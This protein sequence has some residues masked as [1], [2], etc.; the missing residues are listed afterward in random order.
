[1]HDRIIC[2]AGPEGAP[3]KAYGRPVAADVYDIVFRSIHVDVLWHHGREYADNPRELRNICIVPVY[4][5]HEDEAW[6][7]PVPI[8]F[9]NLAFSIIIAWYRYEQ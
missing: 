6:V 7:T 2:A 5:S 8:V 4:H 3:H 1:M 9:D